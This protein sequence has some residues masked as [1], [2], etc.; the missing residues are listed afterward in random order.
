[1]STPELHFNRGVVDPMECFRRAR[2]LITDQ[3]WLF[4]GMCAVGFLIGAAV[5]MGILMGPMMCG[6]YLTFFKRRR[7]EPIE[8]GDLFKG[9][10][11]FAQSVIATLLHAI[12]IVIVVV[13][14]YLL[15]Y[16]SFI[17]SVVAQ[18]NE[19]SVAPVYGVMGL[20]ML[21]WLFVVLLMIFLSVGF[22]FVYPLIV[23]RKLQ[24]LDAIKW[25]FKAAMANFGRLLLLIVLNGLL[26]FAGAL[27]CYVG[28]FLVLPISYGA[29]A[30]AYEQVFGLSNPGD[31]AP[32]LPPPPPKF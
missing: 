18:G 12:P 5:P 22:A 20:F 10:D 30:M 28:M 13:P 21:F 9:F 1:M 31:H 25:S 14:G 32:D 6:I 8:F 23:D 4:V 7:G 2:A 29:L 19:P 26:S 17:F 16:F 15:F 24:A 11:Y 27:L 3:F